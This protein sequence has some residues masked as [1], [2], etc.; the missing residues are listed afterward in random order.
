MSEVEVKTRSTTFKAV[1]WILLGFTIILMIVYALAA[2]KSFKD[3]KDESE[4]DVKMRK[5]MFGAAIVGIFICLGLFV[6]IW[7]ENFGLALT[8]AIVFGFNFGTDIVKTINGSEA[9]SITSLVIGGIVAAL[10][11]YYAYLIKTEGGSACKCCEC[12]GCCN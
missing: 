7:L 3:V 8:L 6:A 4:D 2:A 12:C 10:T 11:G 5:G 9:T 1:K